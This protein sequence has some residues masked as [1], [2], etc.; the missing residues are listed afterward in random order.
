MIERRA[1]WLCAGLVGLMLALSTWRFFTLDGWTV[2]AVQSDARVPALL[3]FAFPAASALVV[4]A[5]YWNG[6]RGAA[7][8]EAK[9]GPWRRWGTSLAIAYCTG[10]LLMLSLLVVRTL[11]LDLPID[12]AAL[13]RA[14][15]L[16]LALVALLAIN[17]MPKLPW[18]EQAF[19]VG[20]ELG[21]V[22]G[23]R[24]LRLQSR[25][26]VVFMIAVIAWSL[27]VPPATA[28]RSV[29]YILIASALLAAWSVV[30]RRRLSRRWKL[31]RERG[32]G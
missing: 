21:P 9:I 20:G 6:H 22:Y 28:W 26:V 1:T 2:P 12:L 11:G 15:G 7:V 30:A 4:A 24:F 18:I 29:V 17:R 10:M 25:V 8:S 14:G 19:K 23:P 5:L 31:E 32:A 13:A 16:V 3:L 27:S